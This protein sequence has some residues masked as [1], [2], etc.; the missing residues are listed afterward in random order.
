MGA[1][2]QLVQQKSQR[3]DVRRCRGFL[4]AQLARGIGARVIGTASA[5]NHQKLQ[6]IGVTPVAYGEGLIER[7]REVAADGVS[8]VADFVGGAQCQLVETLAEAVARIVVTEF[9]VPWTRVSVAKP[10]AV[11]GSR[12]VGVTIE[13]TTEAYG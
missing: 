12:E 13:R 6:D 7:V 2:Q 10:G 8:A 3:M 5:A 1:G 9:G 11:Q 4:A